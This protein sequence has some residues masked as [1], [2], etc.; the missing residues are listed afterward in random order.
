MLLCPK[1]EVRIEE[2]SDDEQMQD[3]FENQ[4]ELSPSSED[5]KA[6]ALD[7]EILKWSMGNEGNIRS[8]IST[9]QYRVDGSQCLLWI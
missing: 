9:L 7:A 1:S 4:V 8:L 2:I 3:L 6:K 5:H